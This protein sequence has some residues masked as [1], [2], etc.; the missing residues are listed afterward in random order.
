MVVRSLRILPRRE[1]PQTPHNPGAG[2]TLPTSAL[3]IES[4]SGEIYKEHLIRLDLGRPLWIPQC[5]QNLSVPYRQ[6]GVRIGDVG[7][8]TPEG[9]FDFLF[10][11]CLPRNDPVNAWA[12]DNFLP[13]SPPL[14]PNRDVISYPDYHTPGTCLLSSEIE[15]S[16]ENRYATPS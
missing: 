10:N 4:R 7:I 8:V 13:L 2:T 15:Q 1:P 12:P 16:C 3:A 6:T 5:N 9:G 11:I 14:D